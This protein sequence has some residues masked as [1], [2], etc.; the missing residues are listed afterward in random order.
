MGTAISF[1]SHMISITLEGKG[2][3]LA[4]RRHVPWMGAPSLGFVSQAPFPKSS[5]KIKS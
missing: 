2:H 4:C 5:R 3:S 1:K